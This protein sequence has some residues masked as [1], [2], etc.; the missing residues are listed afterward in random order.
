MLD[1]IV[2]KT[3]EDYKKTYD[4]ENDD[5]KTR[6]KID[7]FLRGIGYSKSYVKARKERYDRGW[8]RYQ[9]YMVYKHYGYNKAY[10]EAAYYCRKYPGI[11]KDARTMMYGQKRLGK[12]TKEDYLKGKWDAR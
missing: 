4:L 1:T 7:N 10:A 5:P 6:T 12:S 9:V 2:Y 8:A 3:T 11:Y